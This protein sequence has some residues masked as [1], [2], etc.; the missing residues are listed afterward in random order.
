MDIQ[1]LEDRIQI[2]AKKNIGKALNRHA[3]K[4]GLEYLGSINPIGMPVGKSIE[5]LGKLFLETAS[6]KDEEIQK[7]ER[8]AV[9][10][11]LCKI[12]TGIQELAD[13]LSRLS[14]HGKTIF[15]GKVDLN[16]YDANKAI[17]VHVVTPT[18]FRPGS[19]ISVTASKTNAVTGVKIGGD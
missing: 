16:V 12:D 13:Q 8:K 10:D 5:S 3:V 15:A 18:E 1:Q 11:F 19:S 2:E 14:N 7:Q 9:L 4:I 6:V 17:G